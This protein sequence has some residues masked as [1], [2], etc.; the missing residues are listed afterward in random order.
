LAGVETRRFLLER[1]ETGVSVREDK[2][3]SAQAWA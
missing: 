1:T 2:V 3:Q